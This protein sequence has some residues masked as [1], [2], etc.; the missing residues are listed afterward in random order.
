[1]VLGSYCSPIFLSL[2]LKET[3]LKYFLFWHDRVDI[4]SHCGL[5]EH[6]HRIGHSSNLYHSLQWAGGQD[7]DSLGNAAQRSA[8]LK[9]E[10]RM[11]GSFRF[12][13]HTELTLG[14]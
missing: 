11:S 1:M 4:L 5:G 2:E 10:L 7:S 14:N 6:K 13:T 3:F 12:V 9:T 8:Q